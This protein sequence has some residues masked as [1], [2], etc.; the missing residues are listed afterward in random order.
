MFFTYRYL[1][2]IMEEAQRLMRG[3][4]SRS[5]RVDGYR[6]G[7]TLRWRA[8]VAGNMV[9]TLFLRSYERS[10]RV[11]AA[12]QARGYDGEPRF[13]DV[14]VVR[15]RDFLAAGAVVVYGLIVELYANFA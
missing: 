5:A 10:E 2:T 8:R 13:L 15:A 7:G 14:P 4:D 12:M 9:G 11:F 6:S 3:R 1:F